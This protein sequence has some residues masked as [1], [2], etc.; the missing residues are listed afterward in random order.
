MSGE[1]AWRQ[2]YADKFF[3]IKVEDGFVQFGCSIG[4]LEITIEMRRLAKEAWELSG[5]LLNRGDNAVELARFHYLDGKV[6]SQ[7][8]NFIAPTEINLIYGRMYRSSDI[9]RSAV[10][11]M[12]NQWGK[13]NGISWPLLSDPIHES[14]NWALS[15]DTGI[16]TSGWE[17]PGWFFGFTGPGTA[18]GEV[19]YK[20]GQANPDFFVGTLLDN[21]LVES[22]RTRVLEKTVIR[23]GDWQ[24]SLHFWAQ[25]C[26]EEL[27]ANH[28]PHS[29]VGYCSW[30]QCWD[31]VTPDDI[32]R[33]VKEFADYPIPT[34]GR[35][36]Q[37]DDGFA[38][39]PGDWRANDKFKDSLESLP[40]MISKAGFI[41]GIWLAP[42][43]IHETNSIVKEH[44]EWLQRL[45]DGTPA[46]WF[47][48][49]GRTYYLE[50]DHPE[51][52]K[53]M[54]DIFSGFVAQG[55]RYFK[56]DFAYP[57]STARAAYDRTKTSF[58][59]LRGMHKL[60]REACGENILINACIGQPG[61]FA[62]GTSQIARLGRD[63]GHDWATV[64]DNIMVL[65]LRICTNGFWWQ[66]DPDVFSMRKENSTLTDEENYLL[67]GTIGLIGGVFLTSDFPSQWSADAKE[68]VQE[69]WTASGP[70]PPLCY[71]VLFGS[72]GTPKAYRVSYGN[73]KTPQHLIA[74]YNWDSEH[75]DV[76]VPLAK[77]KLKSGISWQLT[78]TRWNRDVQLV[79]GSL[80][81]K[82]QPPHSVRI[83]GLTEIC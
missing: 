41:P 23:Y 39:M 47:S 33:A 83:A 3:D 32:K 2:T 77:L 71:Y 16:L 25:R 64:K 21:I 34:G 5:K 56:I 68:A 38:K 63:I 30:Y 29:M 62:I 51:S 37:I 66:A 13:Q 28:Q 6:D 61:R 82:K 12:E 26:A 67:M 4:K 46:L 14:A 1:K 22:G 27:G 81:I 72:D 7:N 73:D 35:I 80:V 50:P 69:F 15:I 44:P 8:I 58:E 10:T 75:R 52:Q 78:K 20:V 36:I 79:N 65:M 49:W 48:N 24:E 31:K 70:C 76:C 45:S 59:S 54:C 40:E 11:V 9:V 74:V 43:L 42:T 19:G 53:F 57:I 55:W 18:F 60:F 17:Q